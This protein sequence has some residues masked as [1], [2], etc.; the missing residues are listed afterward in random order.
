MQRDIVLPGPEAETTIAADVY[1]D[2]RV[3]FEIADEGASGLSL[4]VLLGNSDAVKLARFL[5]LQL[6]MTL[7]EEG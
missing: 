2:G 3:Y 5:T 7:A 6:G 4:H 1:L